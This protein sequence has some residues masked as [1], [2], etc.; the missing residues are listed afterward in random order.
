M[1]LTNVIKCHILLTMR[2]KTSIR[3][4]WKAAKAKGFEAYYLSDVKQFVIDHLVFA[5]KKAALNYLGLN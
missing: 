2:M 4:I 5:S 3:A 1:P